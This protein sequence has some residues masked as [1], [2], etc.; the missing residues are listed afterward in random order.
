ML[1]ALIGGLALGIIGALLPLTLFSGEAQSSQLLANAA[2]IGVVM[3]I[4][5][6]VVKLFATSL[7]LA[8]GWKGGYI[9]PLMFACIALGLAVNLLFPAIPLAVAVASTMAGAL[10]AALRAPLFAALF[11][12]TLVQVETAPVVAVAIVFSAILGGLLALRTAQRTA[13][14]AEPSTELT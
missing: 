3:L 11:T 10:V 6:A 13:D 9:F 5:L 2:E 14:Q 1:R 4:V 12:L 8:T 7:L